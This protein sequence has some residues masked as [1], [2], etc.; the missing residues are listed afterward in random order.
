M[1][2]QDWNI[3]QKVCSKGFFRDLDLDALDIDQLVGVLFDVHKWHVVFC[4]NLIVSV[5]GEGPF[6]VVPD[7]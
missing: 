7:P 4:G 3:D 5:D 6:G 2:L 1:T